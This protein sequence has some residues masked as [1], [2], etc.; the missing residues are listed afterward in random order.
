MGYQFDQ[1]STDSGQLAPSQGGREEQR[2]MKDL[3]YQN[4]PMDPNMLAD[5]H[6]AIGVLPPESKSEEATEME[7]L[8]NGPDGDVSAESNLKECTDADSNRDAPVQSSLIDDNK[9]E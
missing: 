9:M 6:D 2:G 1:F 5:S 8:Q 7:V 3:T 4:Q